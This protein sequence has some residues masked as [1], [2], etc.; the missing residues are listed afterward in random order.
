[1]FVGLDCG[2]ALGWMRWIIG[3]GRL[4]ESTSLKDSYAGEIV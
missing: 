4:T 3:K 1:M 2:F